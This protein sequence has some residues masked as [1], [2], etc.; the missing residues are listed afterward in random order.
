M[1]DE[2]IPPRRINPALP[3]DLETIVLTAMSQ[4]REDRYPTAQAMADDLG[5][6]LAGRP[7]KARR[8]AL[9]DR[10]AK[11]AR[12]HRPLVAM[13]ACALAAI[14]M[15]SAIGVTLLAREQAKTSAALT[16]AE[17]NAKTAGENFSL[18]QRHFLQARNA[19]DQLGA[20][21]ADRLSTVPGA[22]SVRRDLLLRTLEYYRQFAVE[23]ADDPQLLH[24]LAMAHFKSG[25]I[26]AKLG[27]T[28]EA[29]NEYDASQKL[30]E[31][32]I[33]PES[34]SSTARGASEVQSQLALTHNNIGLLLMVRGEIGAAKQHYE[35]AIELQRRLVQH[36][37]ASAIYAC[38]LAETNGNL[39]MLLDQIG[40]TAAAEKQLR[41]SIEILR[42]QQESNADDA[43]GARNLAIAYNNLSYILRDSDAAA[44]E[45]AVQT[46]IAI[47]EPLVEKHSAHPNY[48]DDLAL[49]CNNLAEIESRQNRLIEAVQ[50]H[51]KAIELEERL[52]RLEPAVV[53]HRSDL[54]T[55]LN[56]LG[57]LLCRANRQ[58]DADAAFH[59]G[60]IYLQRSLTTIRRSR[61]ITVPWR[62]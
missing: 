41:S 42:H 61:L 17:N 60:A 54:A 6:F 32:W 36:C 57:V 50:W 14:T 43:N 37:P 40:D 8:P 48:Q 35:C 3:V 62:L 31:Q 49:C 46:A 16:Q 59:R 27:A 20:Q 1:N 30:L 29:L 38:Q 24:E 23:A 5:R 15:V 58:S 51:R 52:V 7:T 33:T 11:W 55:S 47:L 2:P 10:A 9:A 19:V 25:V 12:R 39:S 56:N 4:S 28:S 21:L 22:D 26:A 53:R 45:M 34:N 18:A 13:A 44:A